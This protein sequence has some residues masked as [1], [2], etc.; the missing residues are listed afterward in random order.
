MRRIPILT[1]RFCLSIWLVQ[2]RAESGF[3]MI[4]TGTEPSLS[5]AE[6]EPQVLAVQS[7]FSS[8]IEPSFMRARQAT[9]N[10]AS[11]AA[12]AESCPANDTSRG[13]IRGRKDFRLMRRKSWA[14]S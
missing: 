10:Q 8:R 1:L 9:N 14:Y 4:L 2:M 12:K 3:P 5:N 13:T 7:S 6:M 11:T